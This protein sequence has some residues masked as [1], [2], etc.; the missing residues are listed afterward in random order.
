MVF[1]G[2]GPLERRHADGARRATATSSRTSSPPIDAACRSSCSAGPVDRRRRHPAAVLG[3]IP[4]DWS[5]G[6]ST[7]SSRSSR[8][9]S[10]HRRAPRP[11]TIR[12]LLAGR[13]HRWSRSLG[14]V[15]AVPRLPEA[16]VKAFEPTILADGWYYDRAV[17][18]FMGGPGR[19]A[20]RRSP[21]STPTSSTAPS[22]ASASRARHGR[23]GPQGADR[24]RP[25][26]R[27]DHRRRRRAAA[28]LVRRRAGILM[29]SLGRIDH[30]RPRTVPD[31]HALHDRSCPTHRRAARSR[32]IVEARGPSRQARSALLSAV[33]HRRR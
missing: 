3:C 7:G 28:R 27:G 5:T 16:R 13:R 17:S 15:V 20:S 19:E 22:T 2:R 21:G 4:D 18:G 32:S 8:S 30:W 10:D 26:L 24:L 31:P 1:F 6:S 25:Q 23:R 12:T 9:A 11:T 29:T 14:I 33:A